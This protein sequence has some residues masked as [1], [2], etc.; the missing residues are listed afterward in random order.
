MR[1]PPLQQTANILLRQQTGERNARQHPGGLSRPSYD[2]W[3]C[4]TSAHDAYPNNDL[5]VACVWDHMIFR[6][7]LT[8]NAVV[9]V[10]HSAG[11]G[12]PL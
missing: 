8:A 5:F 6:K 9:Q 11:A 10:Y 12:I 2:C 7:G 4:S 1:T 3:I